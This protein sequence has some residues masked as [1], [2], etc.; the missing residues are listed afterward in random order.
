M[1][2]E[3]TLTSATPQTL[4]SFLSLFRVIDL[5]VIFCLEIFDSLHCVVSILSNEKP[6]QLI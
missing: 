4:I 6:S 5:L 1:I 2:A 3:F